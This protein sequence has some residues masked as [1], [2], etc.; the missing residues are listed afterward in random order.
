M[1]P[2]L[3]WYFGHWITALLTYVVVLFVIGARQR[4][5]ATILHDAAHGILSRSRRLGRFLGTFVSGYLIL[6]NFTGYVES[7]VVRH[8]G[9]FGDSVLDPD[10]ADLIERGLYAAHVGRRHVIRYLTSLVSP[11]STWRYLRYLIRNRI[12]PHG[13]TTRERILRLTYLTVL[14]VFVTVSGWWPYVLLFWVVPLL[15]SAN[16][17]GGLLELAEHYPRMRLVPAIDLYLSRNRLCG[18]VTNF[19]LGI[20]SEGYHLIHHL[21]PSMPSWHYR[22]AHRILLDD[23]EYRRLNSRQGWR[24]IIAEMTF[25]HAIRAADKETA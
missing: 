3:A 7:H 24:A 23:P 14:G 12:G 21:F 19:F 6:Q 9:H 18:P 16:W 2:V 15:T 4:A 25:Q 17:I 20:H 5:L 22:R 1:I 13:E 10:F 11:A 8:H